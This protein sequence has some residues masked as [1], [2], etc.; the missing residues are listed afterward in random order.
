M[1]FGITSFFS[2]LTK[3]SGIILPVTIAIFIL[4]RRE[5]KTLLRLVLYFICL[6]FVFLLFLSSIGGYENTYRN[7]VLGV[8]NG[9]S[10]FL[11][12]SFFNDKYFIQAALWVII[13]F[14]ISSG[15]F[16]KGLDNKYSFFLDS[17]R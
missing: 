8:K 6:S 4:V 11:I 5:Y 10:L 16:K 15:V 7:V 13:G 3:Q 12:E 14:Y 17:T 2:I 1:L 9:M